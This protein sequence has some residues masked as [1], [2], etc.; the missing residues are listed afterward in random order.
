M[1]SVFEKMCATAVIAKK[2]KK[3]R[4]LDFDKNVR[5]RKKTKASVC[6]YRDH[7]I[8]SAILSNYYKI[9][10]VFLNSGLNNRYTHKR[11]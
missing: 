8:S 5:K 4:F 2:R 6:S 7:S 9:K 1:Q 3:L 10:I 11:I